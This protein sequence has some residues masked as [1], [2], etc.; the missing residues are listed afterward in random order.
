MSDIEQLEQDLLAAVAAAKDEAA[1]EAVRVSALGKNGQVTALLKTLGSMTP[2]ERKTQGPAINGLKD[3]VVGA[4]A[5]RKAALT[6][7]A[8]DARLN[9]EAVDVTL[10][11]REPP[12]ESGRV[13]PISQVIDELTAIF[14][15]MGF[16]VAE[17]PDIETDDYNF[18]K[19]N[20]PEGHPARDMHDTFYFPPKPNGSR[21]LLRTHTSPCRCAPC[22]RRSRRSASSV[23]AAP[24]A[25][26]A[27][28]RTR[29]CSTRSRA[30]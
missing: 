8:L 4:I 30:W 11:V 20:F 2:D 12:A 9:T 24:I 23:P 21:L 1:L 17:G 28:R 14:A 3:R 25:A 10:P 7:A 16:A 22:S 6:D 18:T 5:T 29:P 15:D 13:H 26:T 27:T 19:L